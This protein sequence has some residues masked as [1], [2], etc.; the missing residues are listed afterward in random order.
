MNHELLTARTE[1]EQKCL[2]LANLE[3][4]QN[5]TSNFLKQIGEKYVSLKTSPINL[6]LFAISFCLMI[7]GFVNAC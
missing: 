1:L 6:I 4:S 7:L 3:E 2:Q 5:R